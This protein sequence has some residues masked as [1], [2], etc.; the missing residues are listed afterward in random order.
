MGILT[1]NTNSVDFCRAAAQITPPHTS[2][3]YGSPRRG[4]KDH[5]SRG[6]RFRRD[7][8]RPRQSRISLEACVPSQQM[9]LPHQQKG[10]SIEAIRTDSNTLRSVFAAFH[11]PSKKMH[12]LPRVVDMFPEHTPSRTAWFAGLYAI[13]R[14]SIL[15]HLAPA[16]RPALDPARRSVLIILGCWFRLCYVPLSEDLPMTCQ[17]ARGGFGRLNLGGGEKRRARATGQTRGGQT[18]QTSHEA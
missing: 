4:L 2:V 9:G 11:S 14:L 16:T 13:G 17:G 5:E 3:Q 8:P 18:G 6:R 7:S 12:A 15:S 10:K 1:K